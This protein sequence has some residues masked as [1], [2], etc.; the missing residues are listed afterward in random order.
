MALRRIFIILSFLLSATLP[1]T[2]E[3]K[4]VEEHI[5]LVPAGDVDSKIVEGIK[6]RLP[7]SFPMNVNA[8]LEKH[9]NITEAAYDPSRK[10]YNAETVLDDIS[11]RLFLDTANERALVIVDVDLY[12]PDLNFVFGL[13]NAKRGVCIISLARLKNEFYGLKPDNNLLLDRAVKEAVHEIGHSW[14]LAHCSNPKCVMFF[15]NGLPD[16]DGKRDTFCH[17]CRNK[18]HE[19]YGKPLLGSLPILNK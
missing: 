7:G 15:S 9:E 1:D 3:A 4:V 16:T 14:G 18:L 8:A 5:Y 6:A 12:A 11:G 19:R 13:S 17:D 10:Q 2:S